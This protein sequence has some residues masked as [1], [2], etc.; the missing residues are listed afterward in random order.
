MTERKSP[1]KL[2][3]PMMEMA[4]GEQVEGFAHSPVHITDN[5]SDDQSIKSKNSSFRIIRSVRDNVPILNQ[6]SSYEQL[7]I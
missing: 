4:E 7:S 2:S 1:K 3:V 5:I 6:E